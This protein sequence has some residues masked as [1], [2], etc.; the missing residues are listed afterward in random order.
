MTDTP[1]TPSVAHDTPAEAKA[2]VDPSIALEAEVE[3]LRNE[4]AEHKDRLLRTLA[5][6]ENLRRRTEREV[7]DANTYGITKFA[8]DVLG[9][10]DNLQR[11]IDA[12]PAEARAEGPASLA[13]L[14]G[15][16]LT[17]RTLLQ[18]LERYG[19]KQIEALGARFDPNLHQAMF[20]IPDVSVTNGTILQVLQSGFV[21]ADRVLR[22]ALVG[23]S[24]GGPKAETAKAE[25]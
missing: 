7:K 18:T 5:D 22:P 6:M 16:E 19:V 14:E 24:K 8:R 12:T 4:C 20:E 17:E 21:I 11:A 2:Y 25:G 10:A 1:D 9:I 23:V 3:K 13:L 15:V